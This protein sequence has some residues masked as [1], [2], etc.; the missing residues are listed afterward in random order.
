[1]H[2]AVNLVALACTQNDYRTPRAC[3]TSLW[4]ELTQHDKNLPAILFQPDNIALVFNARYTI[5]IVM[6]RSQ[7]LLL[8]DHETKIIITIRLSPAAPDFCRHRNNI[9]TCSYTN[10][11]Y[12]NYCERSDLACNYER[13]HSRIK[14]SV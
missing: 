3:T 12:N 1:M 13:G 2:V 11:Y 8:H 7:N 4:Y 6:L 14:E 5:D 9:I 10:N